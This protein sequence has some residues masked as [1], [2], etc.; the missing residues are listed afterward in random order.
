MVRA[1]RAA[2]GAVV[3]GREPGTEQLTY[4]LLADPSYVPA[5]Y[6]EDSF[7][8]QI[9]SELQTSPRGSKAEEPSP[10]LPPTSIHNS[11]DF[12]VIESCSPLPQL[13]QPTIQ[14]SEIECMQ[15]LPEPLSAPSDYFPPSA[16]DFGSFGMDSEDFTSLLCPTPFA[17]FGSN[18]SSPSL[19]P[20]AFTTEFE[21][22]PTNFVADVQ[23]SVLERMFEWSQSPEFYLENFLAL[24]PVPEHQL[25]FLHDLNTFSY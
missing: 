9:S 25:S 12:G 17:E 5:T 21:P 19:S 2:S 7:S 8:F 15:F 23:D 22:F 14:A 18:Y 10:T 20:G 11:F 3:R 1:T 6:A 4:E 13:Y 24:P 16:M